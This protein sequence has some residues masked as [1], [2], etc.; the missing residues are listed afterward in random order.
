MWM[1]LYPGLR[2][3]HVPIGHITNGVHVSTWLA[4]QMRQMYERHLGADWA[5]R[6]TV[7]ELWN[8]IETV[9]DGEVWEVHQTLKSRLIDFTRRR[10]VS[11][12][13]RRGEPSS[14][15]SQLRRALSPDALTIGFA[16][17][18]AT[19]KRANLLV[20]DLELIATLV[21]HA[22]MPVQVIFAGKAHPQDGPGKS[23]L[24]QIANLTRDPAFAGKVVFIE[25]YDMNVGRHL[26]QGVDVWLNNPRRPLEACGTSGQKVV[27]NGALN[28]SV[29]DG[30][31]AEAYDGLNGFAIGMG[32]THTSTDIHDGR[33]G[34]SLMSV[35]RDEVVPLY[36][37][38]D[39][40]GLPRA[41]IARMKRAIRTLGGRFSAD[42]MVMD[43]VLNAYI[44]AA[45]GTSSDVSRL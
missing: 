28:L 20:R 41:W 26:V 42:R 32:E 5:A 40:D 8:S 38:R 35:L 1:P 15:L 33:D 6:S 3:D 9:D 4:P 45:G 44:P 31:W 25:D 12:A 17:R 19:Y 30:W 13:E 37:D 23:V 34:T 11:Q 36:Y 29:L 27:L 18:F 2:E 39:R 16:R 24:Q 43:Y 7:P 22:Q 21:N 14:V 10:I